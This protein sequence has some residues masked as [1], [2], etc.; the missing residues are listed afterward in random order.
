MGSGSVYL[1]FGGILHGPLGRM[2][3]FET[4]VFLLDTEWCQ[5]ANLVYAIT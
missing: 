1:A 3:R 2:S 4:L 5:L